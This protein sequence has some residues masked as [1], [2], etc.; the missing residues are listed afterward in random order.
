MASSALGPGSK[1]ESS[2]SPQ[3]QTPTKVSPSSGSASILHQQSPRNTGGGTIASSNG[4]YVS[5]GLVEVSKLLQDGE[6][7][8]KWDDVS[9]CLL[10]ITK[11]KENIKKI[12]KVDKIEACTIVIYRLK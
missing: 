8:V 9:K 12:L 11:Y 5:F 2:Q 3:H 10:I 6:K 1:M 4:T 7:F